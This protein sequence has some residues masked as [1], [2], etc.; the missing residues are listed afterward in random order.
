M[1]VQQEVIK[2][3]HDGRD[4]HGSLNNYLPESVR[5]LAG[6]VGINKHEIKRGE[7]SVAGSGNTVWYSTLVWL[8]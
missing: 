6:R 5:D 3:S 8:H 2:T 4:T 7:K 1:Q